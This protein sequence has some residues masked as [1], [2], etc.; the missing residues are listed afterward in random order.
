MRFA[1]NNVLSITDASDV[2]SLLA[3]VVTMPVA[4]DVVPS[5]VAHVELSAILIA[6]VV[7]FTCERGRHKL[8][9]ERMEG[10]GLLTPSVY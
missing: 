5:S 8:V 2:A 3:D 7:G 6:C 10:T 4:V 1:F 9:C